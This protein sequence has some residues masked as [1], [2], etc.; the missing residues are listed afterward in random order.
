MILAQ[1]ASQDLIRWSGFVAQTE[2]AWQNP[3]LVSDTEGWQTPWFEMEVLNGL[4]LA[5]WEEDGSP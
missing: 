4:A 1:Q 5:E 3:N 2:F